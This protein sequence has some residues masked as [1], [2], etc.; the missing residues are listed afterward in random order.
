MYSNMIGIVIYSFLLFIYVRST[1]NEHYNFPITLQQYNN[2]KKIQKVIETNFIV[3]N[4]FKKILTS[5][6]KIMQPKNSHA[7]KM[8]TL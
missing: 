6:P 4:A 2:L 7:I 3:Q 5:F 8:K 1:T